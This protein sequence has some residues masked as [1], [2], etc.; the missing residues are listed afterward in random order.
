M[1]KITHFICFCLFVCVKVVFH[2]SKCSYLQPSLL[3]SF[4]LQ[5]TLNANHGLLFNMFKVWSSIQKSRVHCVDKKKAICFRFYTKNQLLQFT[6][7]TFDPWYFNFTDFLICLISYFLIHLTFDIIKPCMIIQGWGIN[8][9]KPVLPVWVNFM[10]KDDPTFS[11]LMAKGNV[12][13]NTRF[14]VVITATLIHTTV[15]LFYNKLQKVKLIWRVWVE[16][17]SRQKCSLPRK[18]FA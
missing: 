16:D 17:F 11:Q 14:A 18:Y 7:L 9:W 6:L 13:T 3:S 1:E 10:D 2:L 8:T 4:L 5:H 15:A 12:A